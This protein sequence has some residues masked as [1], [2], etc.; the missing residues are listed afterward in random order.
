VAEHY[1]REGLEK[2]FTR[3]GAIDAPTEEE[4]AIA[5]DRIMNEVYGALRARYPEYEAFIDTCTLEKHPMAGLW[6]HP[7][8][9]KPT[10]DLMV[11]MGLLLPIPPHMR[12]AFRDEGEDDDG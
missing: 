9:S 10:R 7:V 4:E 12:A 3:P 8:L 11:E 5:S 2:F 6:H 1:R